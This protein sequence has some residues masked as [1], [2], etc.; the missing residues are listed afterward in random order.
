MS[1]KLQIPISNDQKHAVWDLGIGTYLEFGSWNLVL[2][3]SMRY[4]VMRKTAF[5]LFRILFLPF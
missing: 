2:L 3:L 5:F 4:A 1:N